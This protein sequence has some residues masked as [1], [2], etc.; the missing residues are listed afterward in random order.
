MPVNGLMLRTAPLKDCQVCHLLGCYSPFVLRV[1]FVQVML[2]L[3]GQHLQTFLHVDPHVLVAQEARGF[4]LE[5]MLEKG[6]RDMSL[7]W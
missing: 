2:M 5:L 1:L 6:D 3:L 7:A 4:S